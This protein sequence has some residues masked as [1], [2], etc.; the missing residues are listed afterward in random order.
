LPQGS[1]HSKLSAI[2]K[3]GT[4]TEPTYAPTA[5][6][7]R[8]PRRL[9]RSHDGRWFGGVCEGLGRYFDVNPAVYRLAFVALALAGGTGLLL[10][11]A[12]WLVIPD[13]G[14]ESS[15]AEQALRD[16]R[17]RPVLAAGVGL[18]GLGAILFFSHAPF[19]PHPGNLW[20]AALLVGGGLVWWELRRREPLAAGGPAGSTTAGTGA[21]PA[22][23]LPPR[24]SLLL[25]VLG[26]LLAA[27]GVLGLL[28]AL[29]ALSVDWRIALAGAEVGVGV[30]I[31][32]GSLT[33][34]RVAG[35]VGL[36]L[37]LLPLL[38][39][40]LAI[41][42]PL[43]GGVG[44]R[45]ERPAAVAT[46]PGHYRLAVGTL[47]L[48]LRDLALPLGETT[49]R[50]SV[51]VGELIVDVP[52]GAAVEVTGRAGAGEVTLFGT[53]QNGSRVEVHRTSGSGAHRLVLD[54]RV[55]LGDVE[56]RD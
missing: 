44:D 24:R 32:V 31:L 16:R 25:P 55:G 56:V 19:W 50:A 4:V 20:L 13:E 15:L 8:P 17:D 41:D 1:R 35:L 39:L 30:A 29:D 53:R 21:A 52:Q 6:D 54:L 42:V 2:S 46:I 12:A 38:M 9:T 14:R 49:V 36:E 34:W 45:S 51:G 40:A 26:A 37:L 5:A 22:P 10:Y 11:L 3:G 43:R 33:G 28:D 18:V 27:V 23:P 47:N 7:P 48:D